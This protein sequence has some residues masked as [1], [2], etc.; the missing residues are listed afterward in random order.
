MFLLNRKIYSK[1]QIEE[2]QLP[3]SIIAE[4]PQIEDQ[5]N[6]TV[7]SSNERSPL[8]ES[9]RVFYSKLKFYLNNDKKDGHVIIVTS[10]VK[11]EGKTFVQLI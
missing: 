6:T 8:V 10:T 7:N 11:G 5:T 9:F 4:I 2:L 3:I 1:S